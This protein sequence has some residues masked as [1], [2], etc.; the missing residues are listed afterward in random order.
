M[1]KRQKRTRFVLSVG[2]AGKQ[3]RRVQGVE[4]VPEAQRESVSH[5]IIATYTSGK[6]NRSSNRSSNS[7]QQ[8]SLVILK[9]LD[10]NHH[11]YV[12]PAEHS[13]LGTILCRTHKGI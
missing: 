11:H 2:R 3:E 13:L 12:L 9:G 5:F 1:R 4:I 8:I 6:I 10:I 7:G